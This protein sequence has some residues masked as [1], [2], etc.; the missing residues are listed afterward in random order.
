MTTSSA[1]QTVGT[2]FG[3]INTAAETVST[4]LNTATKSVG[5]LDRFVS[6]ASEKQIIRSVVDMDDFERMLLEEKSAEQAGRTVQVATFKALST[7]H[8]R[9]YDENHARISALLAA[10]K[11]QD[12]KHGLKVAA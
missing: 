8:E 3:T 10:R 11:P 12:N 1:R 2:V 5:M 6:D 9:L 4:V 7:E